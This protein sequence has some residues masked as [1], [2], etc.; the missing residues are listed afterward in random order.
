LS[1]ITE[2]TVKEVEWSVSRHGVLKPVIILTKK[3]LLSGAYVSRVTGHNAKNIKDNGI[4]KGAII[5]AT[6]SGEVIP[7][8]LSTVKKTKPDFPDPST[9]EWKGV[10]IIS[11]SSDD[12]IEITA[13]KL[14]HFLVTIGVDKIKTANMRLLV[15]AGI[16]T[17]KLLVMSNTDDFTDAGMGPANSQ[18]LYN[19]LHERLKQVNH[20]TIGDASGIFPSSI[21]TRILETIIKAT[22]TKALLDPLVKPHT[23]RNKLLKVEG[24]GAIRVEQFVSSL[25]EFRRFLRQIKWKPA[26]R[27]KVVPKRGITGKTFAFTG[28]RDKLLETLI[29]KYGGLIGGLTKSTDYLVAKDP[30]SN[31]SKVGKAVSLGIA[32]WSVRKLQTL[33]GK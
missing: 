23:L 22:G 10:D 26:A 15:A 7:K 21:G 12:Q 9:W 2:A 1:E 24:L 30:N 33:L 18:H 29:V 25:L 11:T 4:G 5:T 27:A 20:A 3:V 14:T 6:R 31:S 8:Y 16:D 19:K 32:V 17:I 13:K 28:I